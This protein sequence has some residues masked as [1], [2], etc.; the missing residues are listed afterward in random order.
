LTTLLREKSSRV[1]GVFYSVY[2]VTNKP[3]Y[4]SEKK[5]LCELYSTRLGCVSFNDK[6]LSPGSCVERDAISMA[7]SEREH[8]C[9]GSKDVEKNSHNL[10]GRG[11]NRTEQEKI[12]GRADEWF[13]QRDIQ[14][15]SSTPDK[16][17][18]SL[19][20]IASKSIPFLIYHLA[21][22]RKWLES[23][24]KKC[25]IEVYNNPDALVNMALPHICVFQMES[26]LSSEKLTSLVKLAATNGHLH[27]IQELLKDDVIISQKDR[28]EAVRNAAEGGHLEVMQEL[29]KND[30]VILREDWKSAV[31]CAAQ[32]D[33]LHIVRELVPDH[34]NL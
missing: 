16:F 11:I 8:R 1:H 14:H 26:K 34:I 9:K 12:F 24:L 5:E 17:T 10:S 23:Y 15:L 27:I 20:Q 31:R 19:R 29:L 32:N 3:S 13:D 4:P 30:A 28:G 21:N 7:A 33:H 2:S 6:I 18:A 22:E 25:L